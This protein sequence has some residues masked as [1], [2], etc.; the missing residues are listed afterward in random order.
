LIEQIAFLAIQSCTSRRSNLPLKDSA[1]D[2][3][4]WK[5]L[6]YSKGVPI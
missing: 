2:I 1:E 4:S 3:T 6:R 5:R